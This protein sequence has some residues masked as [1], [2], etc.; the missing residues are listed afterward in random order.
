M[1]VTEDFIVAQGTHI[2]KK[3]PSDPKHI[4]QDVRGVPP[5]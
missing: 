1:T 4:R 2:E 5:I 3:G